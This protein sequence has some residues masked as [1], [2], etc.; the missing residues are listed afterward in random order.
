MTRARTMG[1][2]KFR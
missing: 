1:E 2:V